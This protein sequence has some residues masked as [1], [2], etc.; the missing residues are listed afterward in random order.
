MGKNV[1]GLF[2]AVVA[3]GGVG[4]CHKAKHYDANVE[5]TRVSVVRRDENGRA[6]TTDVEFSYVECPGTQIETIRGDEAF[7]A[8]VS[9][10]P[11][12]AKVPVKVEHHWD[13]DGQYTWD[14]HQIADCKRTPDPNDEASFAVVRECQDL[15][16]NGASVGF[17]CQITPKKELLAKCPWFGKH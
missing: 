12:G 10:H 1:Q 15:K 6:L 17:E 11:V 3:L 13:P 14:V 5:I 7:S 16:V 8:C 9:K 4:G 2:L